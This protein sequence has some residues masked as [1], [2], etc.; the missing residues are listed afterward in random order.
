MR[1]MRAARLHEFGAPM[2][3]EQLPVPAPRPTDVLVEVR[4]CGVVPNLTNVL[5]HWRNW[6]PELPL[7][8]LPAIFGLDVAGVVAEVGELVQNFKAGDRV[9]V[10]PG[11]F[12]GSC[13]ACRADDTINCTNFTFRGYFG[14]GPD[15]QRQFDA[16]P[17]GG[18]SEFITAP[19]H[20]LV[21]IPD[22]ASFEAAARFGYLGTAYAG[23][24]KANVGP[25]S[26]LL[27]NGTSG[28]L[29]L[30]AVLIA[31]GRGV[32]RILGTARDKDR[33]AHVKALAPGRIEV[34]ADGDGKSVADWA[35]AFTGG[36]G[37]DA[38]IDCLGPQSPGTLMMDAIYA[39]KRGG[40]AVNVSGVSDKVAMDVHWMM[41]QQ[42]EFIGSNWFPPSDAEAMAEMVRAGTLDLSVFEHV[43]FPLA[44]VNRALDGTHFRDGGFTNLVIVP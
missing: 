41:D 1:L 2:V 6:F 38:V 34:L 15:S 28:T 39:L 10:T 20:N 18:M 13:P 23:I 30:G 4:A 11:L 37:V 5:T 32:T 27:I 8:R 25:G 40:R 7:P 42:I 29:G 3:I 9:Y 16:Y 31:L 43:R 12:C 26:T 44:E 35:R 17:Y 22:K 36:H 33:L 24:R 19:Q 14:F 21:A